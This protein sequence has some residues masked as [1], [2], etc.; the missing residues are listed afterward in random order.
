MTATRSGG[1]RDALSTFLDLPAWGRAIV[2]VGA[3]L[4]VMLAIPFL[5]R[6]AGTPARTAAVL[7]LA[8]SLPAFGSLMPMHQVVSPERIRGR[9]SAC[10]SGRP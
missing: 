5:E 8:R 2:P 9:N 10:W 7:R 3:W 4:I 1:R 6:A